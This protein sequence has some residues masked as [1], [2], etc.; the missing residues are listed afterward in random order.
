MT[1]SL[2][3]SV[4]RGGRE[5]YGQTMVSYVRERLLLWFLV[6]KSV[7]GTRINTEQIMR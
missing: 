3:L 7:S 1:V 6:F 5:I 4:S 2:C